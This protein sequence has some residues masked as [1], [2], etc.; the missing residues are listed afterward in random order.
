MANTSLKIGPSRADYAP[1]LEEGRKLETWPAKGD[2]S[3]VP[4]G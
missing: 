3:R 1:S 4:F 2:M